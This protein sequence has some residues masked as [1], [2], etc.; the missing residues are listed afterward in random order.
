MLTS[1]RGRFTLVVACLLLVALLPQFAGQLEEGDSPVTILVLMVASS[2]GVLLVWWLAWSLAGWLLEPLNRLASTIGE[3]DSST[4][5][6][7]AAKPW[8]TE[9]RAI[10]ESADTAV[11]RAELRYSQGMIVVGGFLHDL[12]APVSGCRHLLTA[13]GRE[14]DESRRAA[15]LARVAT[16]LNG[17]QMLVH[18]ALS[19]VSSSMPSGTR[20]KW[21]HVHVEDVVASA[22]SR[23]R[24]AATVGERTIEL[25]GTWSATT[26]PN[27][28]ERTC[29]N[30]L[31]N[32]VRYARS[33]V[34]VHVRPGVI[35]FSD[36]GPGMPD[37]VVELVNRGATIDTPFVAKSEGLGHG[38]GLIASMTMMRTIGA[39]LV[40]ESAGG[41][42]TTVLL[43][44]AASGPS[45][46]LAAVR[47]VGT[48]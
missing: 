45:D 15:I 5:R 47:R 23:V 1:L 18:E 38:I 19:L 31:L 36:D 14:G 2:L 34:C 11:K 41:A 39:R 8:P 33:S 35:V 27:V 32:A 22:I 21:E 37:S 30:I 40:V 10:A 28:L 46:G 26:E 17:V 48:A 42:G 7:F 24:W 9:L 16:E 6:R 29:E 43:Y 13:I 20:A 12:K 25:N 3:A 4:G 44:L